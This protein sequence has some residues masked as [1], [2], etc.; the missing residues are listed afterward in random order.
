MLGRDAAAFDRLLATTHFSNEERRE[1]TRLLPLIQRC[2]RSADGLSASAIM[3][4]GT[5][6]ELL[7]RRQFTTP[8][9]PR[10]PAIGMAPLLR[11]ERARQ[12]SEATQLAPTYAIM[13]CTAATRQDLVL[14]YLATEAS[15]DAEQT[16]FRAMQPAMI[17]CVPQGGVRQLAVDGPSMRR[18]LAESLYRWSSVQRD[19]PTSPFAAGATSAQ[20]PAQ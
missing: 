14:A 9:T 13:E 4:R 12:P 11:P 6:A 15:S 10:T 7:Y 19:G 3:L 2:R 1:A 16:A 8:V 17:A 5:A 20:A 18:I